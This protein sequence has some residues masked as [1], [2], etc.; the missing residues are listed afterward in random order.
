MVRSIEMDAIIGI[1][2]DGCK[3]SD[4]CR[5]TSV[6]QS[7]GLSGGPYYEVRMKYLMCTMCKG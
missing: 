5:G 2:S 1:H 3:H 4:E 7:D 6:V